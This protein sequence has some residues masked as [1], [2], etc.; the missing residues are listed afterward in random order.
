V[1]SRLTRARQALRLEL[2]EA[3]AERTS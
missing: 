1:K 3:L 2:R